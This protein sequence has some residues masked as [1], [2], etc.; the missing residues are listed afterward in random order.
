MKRGKERGRKREGRKKPRGEIENRKNEEK[1]HEKRT[2]SWS[3]STHV[4]FFCEG[5]CSSTRPSFL[6]VKR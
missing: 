2:S 5:K 4:A 1:S 6:E 3:T